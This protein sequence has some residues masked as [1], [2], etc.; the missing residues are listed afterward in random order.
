MRD[1]SLPAI[2]GSWATQNLTTENP[3]GTP[4]W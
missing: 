2:G 4:P 3:P 1:I